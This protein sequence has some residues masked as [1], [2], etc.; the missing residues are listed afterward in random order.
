MEYEFRNFQKMYSEGQ[1]E[2]CYELLEHSM[3]VMQILTKARA[4]AGISFA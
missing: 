1:L 3:D 2:A 4:Q